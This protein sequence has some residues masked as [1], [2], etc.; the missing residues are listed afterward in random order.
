MKTGTSGIRCPNQVNEVPTRCTPR[1]ALVIRKADESGVSVLFQHLLCKGGRQSRVWVKN[2]KTRAK[3]VTA[4]NFRLNIWLREPKF[5]M[6]E[7]G[8][9]EI[10]MK[11]IKVS[12]QHFES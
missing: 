11:T 7:P 1:A 5:G 4:L 3:S 10:L 12:A 6:A 2:R 8:K 9:S